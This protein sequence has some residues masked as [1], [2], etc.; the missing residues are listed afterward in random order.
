MPRNAS[1]RRSDNDFEILPV[2]K[3]TKRK[4]GRFTFSIP[5]FALGLDARGRLFQ[6]IS[7][8]LNVSEHGCRFYLEKMP[9]RNSAMVLRVLPREGFLHEHPRILCEVAWLLE[10]SCGWEVGV[11]VLGDVGIW[12]LAFP[13]EVDVKSGRRK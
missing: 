4:E 5:I 3:R 9:D 10:V 6:Q 7:T 2:P 8:T 12:R 11:H 13:E 1:V